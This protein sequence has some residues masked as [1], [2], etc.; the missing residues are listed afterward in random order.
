MSSFA[1]MKSFRELAWGATLAGTVVVATLWVA[2]R[3]VAPAPPATLVIATASKG[4]PYF[5]SAQRYRDLLAA[6]GVELKVVETKGTMQNLAL[7]AD[8]AS[9]VDAAFL[10]GGVA[11]SRSAPDVRSLG[12]VFYEPV[13]VFTHGSYRL[14]RLTEL[15]G[16][17]VL[18]GPAGSATA[19]LATRL[20]AISG[21]TPD[22]AG[23]A[24][25]ELP[26]YVE[27]LETGAA[28]AGVLVLAPEAR[29]VRRLLASP[30]VKLM[31]V[32]QADAYVQRFPFLATLELKEGV[33]DFARNI[34]PADTRILTTTTALVIRKDLHPAVANLLTQAMMTVHGQPAVNAEGE[35]GIFHRAAV[36]PLSADQ[37]FP[38]SPEAARVYKSGP[39]FLQRYLPLWLAAEADRLLVLLVPA[40]GI[41][42]PAFRLAPALYTWRM[43]RRIIR[44]YRELMKVEERIGRASG[45]ADIVAAI[46]EIDGIE[47]A[48]SRLAVP[49]AFANQLYDLR[50]HIGV[51][52]RRISAMDHA[53]V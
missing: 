19:A 16:K 40:I 45:H 52:R 51:V 33:I 20:L 8:P 35:S 50:E 25:M 18:I 3:I 14:T 15:A 34:P 28:D 29:T 7:M 44:W 47:A 37:E 30:S 21:V 31:N 27:A 5:E 2:A 13:W 17:R 49:M 38:L 12:R 4:S 1:R 48:A 41:L 9:G 36:F 22:T 53:T 26:D 42:V 10:Q 39:P 46:G 11:D 6:A 23:L 43:R 24:N 32:T